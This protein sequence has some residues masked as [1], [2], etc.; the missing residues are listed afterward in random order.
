MDSRN[1]YIYNKNA[2]SYSEQYNSV[3]F[4]QVHG[5]WLESVKLPDSGH[6]LD[7]GSGSGRDAFALAQ[8]GFDVVAC[9]PAEKFLE[10]AK[11]NYPS[12]SITW[13]QDSLPSLDRIYKL[14][15]K[16]DLILLSAVWMHIAPSDRARSF[17]KLSQL[18][19]PNGMLIITLRHGSS[20]DDRSMF[21]V[22]LDELNG[23]ARQQGLIESFADSDGTDQ[24][25]REEVSWETVIF[26][27]PDD[28][29]GAFPL[30]RNIVV[31]DSKSSSYKLGLLRSLIRIAEGHPGAVISRNADSVELP[32]GLVAFYWI[33]L[34]QPLVEKLDLHQNSNA[35]QGLG[36]ITDNGWRAIHQFGCEDFQ[37]GDL[38]VVP[39]KAKAI[40]IALKDAAQTIQRMPSK[41]I[42]LPNSK[43]QVFEV[44]SKR[45]K[46]PKTLLIDQAFLASMGTFVVP[47]AIWDNLTRYSIW[48]EPAIVNEWARLLLSFKAN[49]SK[50]I[51]L[52]YCLQGLAWSPPERSTNRVRKRVNEL[53]KQSDVYCCWSNKRLELNSDF[54]V[55]HCFPFARWPNNDL[56]NLLPSNVAINARKSDKLPSAGK[57]LSAKEWISH[58][59]QQAW[60]ENETE[61]FTQA[62][63]SLPQLHLSNESY[64]DVFEAMQLQRA[65][66][67]DIQQL[68][69]WCK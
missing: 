41:Y 63:L 36:F 10:I 20:P 32:L 50:H 67:K 33:K 56:W 47:V 39:H 15:I 34:Y 66:L 6:A 45:V 5:Q 17:R 43:E 30:L 57:L 55:D 65:R 38:Y 14:D 68:Q 52:Q 1:I 21:P 54:A 27:L 58:W 53:Q 24:L 60:E 16:F 46:T 28:G 69:E 3:P 18:L 8:R 37:V 7:I 40:F 13:L 44:E 31:N 23:F 48:I 9:E 19:K 62:N 49:Q 25:K 35:Q 59:W 29:S 2:V 4:E 12:P 26:S 61:F 51:T 11:C 64:S 42:T 22:N